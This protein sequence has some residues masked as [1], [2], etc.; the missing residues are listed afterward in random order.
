[1][2]SKPIVAALG[3]ELSEI[4][5]RSP[6]GDDDRAE[7]RRLFATRHLLVF[8]RQE[9]D[10]EDQ[11]RAVAALGP[12]LPGGPEWV[13]NVREHGLVPEGRLLFHSDFIFT[14]EP[15]L[16]L[17]LY[18][19]EIP[20]DGSP[21]VFASTVRAARELPP[22]LRSRVSGRSALNIF[23]LTDQ[24]GDVRFHEDALGPATP[25]SPRHAH[26]IL[27]RH[28][29]TGQQVLTVNEMQTDYIVDMDR[30][31]SEAT[32]SSLRD[33]LYAPDNTYTHRWAVGD[34]VIWDNIAIQHGRPS[35]PRHAPRTL[36]RVTMA[37]RDVFDLV[38][39]FTEARA[40]LRRP[41]GATRPSVAE[42]P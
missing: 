4:D 14:P 32:L 16:G 18:A 8:P 11:V 26:P 40:A 7:L 15:C 13:S 35:P 25:L 12:V 36:R 24:R 17:S 39:G 3:V 28:P 5:L 31:A 10:F 29:T 19:T 9:L 21:T 22:D 27:M 1:M 42:G 6:L 38:P 30:E 20:D 23:D 37:N 41:T 2:E 33:V 34:L